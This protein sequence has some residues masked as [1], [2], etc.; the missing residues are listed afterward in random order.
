MS[1]ECQELKNIKYQTM[2]LNSNSK[3]V[4]TVSGLTPCLF[5]RGAA[6]GKCG[7]DL[8]ARERELVCPH[9]CPPRTDI[10]SSSAVYVLDGGLS[11]QPR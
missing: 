4:S 8:T 1:E 9:D 7:A 6:D 3:I 2:L 10:S 5:D 11:P